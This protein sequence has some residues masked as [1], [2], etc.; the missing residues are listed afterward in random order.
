MLVCPTPRKSRT[1]ST[2]ILSLALRDW[3]LPTGAGRGPNQI[4]TIKTSDE[5]LGVKISL[6]WGEKEIRIS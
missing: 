6:S 4:Q 3:V 2:K 5:L 1:V